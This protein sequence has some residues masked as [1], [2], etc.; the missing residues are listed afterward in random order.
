MIQSPH[1]IW[2]P[3]TQMSSAEPPPRVVRG[4][5]V[6]F[7]LEDGTRIA[8][9]ISSWWTNIHG[10][11]H[12]AIARAIYEQAC[13]LDH[14]IFAEFSHP[15][16]ERLSQLLLQVLPPSLRHVFFSDNGS[17]AVEVALKMAF[18]Y[19]WNLGKPRRSFIAFD[20]AYHG[21]TTGAMSLGSTSGFFMPFEELMFS[22]TAAPFPEIHESGESS[23]DIERREADSISFIG[24]ALAGNPESFAAIVVEPLVQ[25]AGGMRICRPEFLLK[26][27]ELARRFDIPL[28]YDEVMTGFGRTGDWFACSKSRTTPDIICLSKGITGGFLPLS[29]TVCNDK[30]YDAFLST[31]KRRTFYH[32]HSYTANPL[33]CAA[34]VASTE[35]L[36]KSEASFM[37]MEARHWRH[38]ARL[39]KNQ[40]I[41][42]LR[43]CGT[44]A[45]MEIKTGTDNSYFNEIGGR[46]K[47]EFLKRGFLIRPLGNTV[48]LM[49]P[50]CIDEDTLE[51]AY[52]C[53]DEVVAALS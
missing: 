38:A 11:S 40:S 21:D 10:H 30:I 41:A 13:A 16:A 18:Q 35:L 42:N 37:T 39:R 51:G 19:W 44:I 23:E 22:I 53:I 8:D 20:G 29:V 48:Y 25:G 9:M 34:A 31:D 6:Y 32:G 3:F 28:I 4:E 49:P 47:K 43:V 15:P 1:T 2:R 14:T 26:L 33:A 5:G 27:S 46:L 50:Y 12:P 24:E 45:A 52:A 7:Y 36:M 17:T